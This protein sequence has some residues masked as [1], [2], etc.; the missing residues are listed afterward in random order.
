MYVSDA[1]KEKMDLAIYLLLL[2]KVLLM[3]VV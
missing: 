3:I 2:I 1:V